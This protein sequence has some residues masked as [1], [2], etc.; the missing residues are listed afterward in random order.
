MM[1]KKIITFFEILPLIMLVILSLIVSKEF[2]E[3]AEKAGDVL[4]YV[5]LSVCF[6]IIALIFCTIIFY[7][8]KEK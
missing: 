1:N 3:C 8:C 7:K 5:M 2:L 6:I 4:L